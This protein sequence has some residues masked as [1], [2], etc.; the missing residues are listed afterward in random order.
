MN[1]VF[2]AET[3]ILEF[4][5]Q[6]TKN[7][8]KTVSAFANYHDG[9]IVIGIDD[10]LNIVG[11]DDYIYLKLKLENA[12]N[13]NISPKPY[14]EINQ[15]EIEGKTIIVLKVHRGEN[16]PYL[17]D[18][19]AYKRM[20][21]STIAVDTYDYENLI[22]NGRNLGFDELYYDEE[23]LDFNYLSKVLRDKLKIGMIS[24]DI[25]KTLGL[26]KN[27]KYINTAALLSDN[28]PIDNAGM[29]LIRFDGNSVANIKDRLFLN[30]ISILEIFDKSIDFYHKH[31]ITSEIINSAYRKTIEQ[32]PIVAY[33]E[34]VA[35]AIVHRNYSI[36][37]ET[38]I[39]IYDNRIEIVSPGGLPIGITE[40][41]Y[42]DGRISVSRNKII[43]D[44]FFRLGI[45]ERLAT[46]IRRIKEYYKD[47]N[48][49][50][51]FLIS[52]NSIKIILPFTNLIDL[53][54]DRVNERPNEYANNISDNERTLINY[55]KK[56]KQINRIEAEKI[57]DL[58][59]THTI[60]VLNT[61]IAK[62]I[63]RRIGKGRNTV[64][65]LG[66]TTI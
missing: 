44:I 19:K 40:E 41:E 56:N 51:S 30:N 21:T 33:R 62:G 64:Y 22:L 26:I 54:S 46:G 5:R 58:K 24:R 20:D 60:E 25:L 55:I 47:Y 18:N 10:D 42:I 11:L 8:L 53:Q 14:Y 15:M 65:I 36:K 49:K 34:A 35:N 61:L 50:P 3:R 27:E 23:N 7:I 29:S 39:E 52:K 48:V 59:K 9:E 1:R 38:R 31:I 6:Y 37:A 66:S 43:S 45:I 17:Y 63:I 4:K 12:I 13:D 2:N 57:L 28:N 32:V 16:T